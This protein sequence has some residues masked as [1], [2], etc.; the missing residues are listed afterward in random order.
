MRA[1]LAVQSLDYESIFLAACNQ[2]ELDVRRSP[3]FFL[4]YWHDGFLGFCRVC[5]LW[6]LGYKQQAG[7]DKP[8]AVVFSAAGAFAMRA[9]CG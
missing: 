1:G 7:H 9:A 5:R 6:W 3:D 8:C 2:A 4:N